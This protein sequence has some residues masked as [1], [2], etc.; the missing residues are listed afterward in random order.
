MTGIAIAIYENEAIAPMATDTKSRLP[1]N[2]S[3]RQVPGV[4]APG[5]DLSLH[6]LARSVQ[7]YRFEHISCTTT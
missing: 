3:G 4:E 6:S 5:G 2:T 7:A 1:R